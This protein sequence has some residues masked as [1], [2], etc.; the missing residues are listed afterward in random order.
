M[1]AK[2]VHT[3]KH[4]VK[5]MVDIQS[6]RGAPVLGLAGMMNC[7]PDDTWKIP[8]GTGAR[9]RSR[10]FELDQIALPG[11]A[12]IWLYGRKPNEFRISALG[13]RKAPEP[14]TPGGRPPSHGSHAK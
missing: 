9:N 8:A 11:S 2:I 4:T 1:M 6:A 3:A 7:V 13:S 10:S 5:A 14:D 12:A